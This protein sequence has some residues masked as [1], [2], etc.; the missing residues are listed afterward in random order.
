M[1]GI[2][3]RWSVYFVHSS[4]V[5]DVQQVLI[6]FFCFL[7]RR[8]VFI[9]PHPSSMG[10]RWDSDFLQ[11][12]LTSS[13]CCHWR[14]SGCICW[15]VWDHCPDRACGW[16]ETSLQWMVQGRQ[17]V[18]ISLYFVAFIMPLNMTSWVAPC[19]KISPHTWT[20]GGCLCLYFSLLGIFV[21]WNHFLVALQLYS[22]LICEDSVIKHLVLFKAFLAPVQLFFFICI[23]N[24]LT[25]SGSGEGPA[26]LIVLLSV[27]FCN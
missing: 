22:R 5:N 19:Y 10:F 17:I 8:H 27:D 4:G 25:V 15:C 6:L 20:L 23:P 12:S 26:K 24:F 16:W 3:F 18:R 1:A 14:T 21:L 9:H 11:D 7:S 2:T 13:L